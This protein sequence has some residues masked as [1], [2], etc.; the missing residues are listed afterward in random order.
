VNKISKYI[1]HNRVIAMLIVLCL[2]ATLFSAFPSTVAKAY[3]GGENLVIDISISGMPQEYSYVSF[4]IALSSGTFG[5]AGTVIRSTLPNTTLPLDADLPADLGKIRTLAATPNTGNSS[6]STSRRLNIGNTVPA[7]NTSTDDGTGYNGKLATW[8]IPLY[9]EIENGTYTFTVTPYAIIA[10]PNGI[11]TTYGGSTNANPINESVFANMQITLSI[12]SFT[13]GSTTPTYTAT[14]TSTDASNV[15]VG[16]PAFNVAV[17]MTASDSAQYAQAQVN[18]T[19]DSTKVTP[20]ITGLDNVSG[21][22]GTLTITKATSDGKDAVVGPGVPL[23]TIPFTATGEG[24]ATFSVSEGA[25]VSFVTLEGSVKYNIGAGAN[26]V[27]P[28]AA[29]TPTFTQDDTYKGLPGSTYTL[30]KYKIDAAEAT[31]V[32]TYGVSGPT[33]HLIKVGSDYFVTYIV[34]KTEMTAPAAPTKTSA[35]YSVSANIDGAGS[36]DICDSQI[37]FDLANGYAGYTADTSFATLTIAQRL[38]A[39]VNGDGTVTTAD[40]QAIIYAI[41]HSGQLPLT[42]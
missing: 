39:D 13:V 36:V 3:S 9:D 32:W 34:L 27:V 25:S 11:T 38:A 28:I 8:T 19:Y 22:S 18:L 33:M 37:A 7:S 10:K 31:K 42:A 41:H 12:S 17:N 6:S 2:V 26:L 5:N 29:A 23:A 24:S 20:N 30:L 4:D 1:P 14:A 35:D 16:D 15:R 40:A 21:G